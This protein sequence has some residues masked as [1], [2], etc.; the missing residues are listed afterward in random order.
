MRLVRHFFIYTLLMWVAT[1]ADAAQTSLLLDCGPA[2]SPLAEGHTGISERDHYNARRGYG[3]ETQDVFARDVSLGITDPDQAKRT[4]GC[5]VELMQTNLDDANGDFVASKGDLTFRADMKPGTYRVRLRIGD[6]SQAIGSMQIHINGKQ[7]A[8]N[9][10]S[11][12]PGGARG[13]HH[14]R[15]MTNPHGAWRD[16][17]FVVKAADGVIKIKMHGDDSFYRAEVKRQNVSEK[18]WEEDNR[19]GPGDKGKPYLRVDVTKA[20]Y[21]YVGWPF[22]HNAIQAIEIL[23]W[24]EAPLRFVKDRLVVSGRDAKANKLAKLFNGGDYAKLESLLLDQGEDLSVSQAIAA[25]ALAGRLDSEEE[26]ALI[27][28]AAKSLE[29]WLAGNPDAVEV[30]DYLTDAKRYLFAEILHVTRGQASEGENHFVENCRAIAWWWQIR[31][32]SPLY[33]KARLFIAR[34]AKMLIP[35][36]PTRGTERE[37]F[38]ELEK[39]YPDNRFVQYH[40]HKTWRPKGDG[41]KYMDWYMPDRTS[42]VADSPKWVADFYTGFQQTVDWCE[43]W[44]TKKQQPEGSIGG[45][46]SDDV[47]IVGLFGYMGY[48]SPDISEVLVKGTG[49]LINGMWYYSEVDPKR[50]YSRFCADAEH[51]TEP[52]GNTLGMMVQI[53]H[54]NPLWIERSLMTA[55]LYRDLWSGFND[56]GFR[57]YKANYFGATSIGG[58]PGR[59]NDTWINYRALRPMHAVFAYNN[60]PGIAQLMV[61]SG[62]A[63]VDAAM[64]TDRGKPKG[65]IPQ[66]VGWPDGKLGGVQSKNWYTPVKGKGLINGRFRSQGYKPHVQEILRAAYTATLDPKYFEPLRMEYDFVKKHGSLPESAVVRLQAVEGVTVKRKGG[67]G[68]RGKKRAPGQGLQPGSDKW[69]ADVLGNVKMWQTAQ[70]LMK[71]RQGKL[72]NDVTLDDAAACGRHSTRHFKT[73]WPMSTTEAGPTDRIAFFGCVNPFLVATGGWIGGPLL[74][75]SV[76]YENTTRHFAAAVLATDPQGLRLVYHSLSEDDREVGLSPWKLQTGAEYKLTWGPDA[77]NDGKMDKKAGSKTFAFPQIGTLVRFP[78]PSRKSVVVE[79]NQVKAPAR[80]AELLA[81]PGLS[82][83]DLK[84]ANGKLKVSIHNVGAAEAK[85]VVVAAYLGDPA[86]GGKE[87]GRETIEV[88]PPISMELMPSIITVDFDWTGDARQ[89]VHAVIDP[90]GKLL[91]E[92][93]TFNNRAKAQL[94]RTEAEKAALDPSEDTNAYT[95]RRKAAI[96]R[97]ARQRG[98]RGRGR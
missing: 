51:T 70:V 27:A 86:Q 3:W 83:R 64:R 80:E 2:G 32:G 1:A 34:S 4:Y 59:M 68:G 39:K 96:K 56:K 66:C 11:W 58:K 8:K 9:A 16:F 54:G 75:A 48:V 46:F 89:E 71:G 52:T 47:E 60:H 44:I 15:L 73:M 95:A 26:S 42:L 22:V 35:Y 24:K 76:T 50:G 79:I 12:S 7:V 87:I 85:D 72:R 23:P 33:D 97:K 57:H 36:F 90:D 19:T 63:W 5:F 41:S 25:L 88:L 20:P 30:S 74:E 40:L 10:A 53:D 62:D 29:S 67:R 65:I 14:R 78:A 92:I 55:R 69:V 38:K 31:P 94:P 77:D 28:N 18:Q 45:G 61:E 91:P 37:I 49:K 93:T 43:W 21:Y 6:M 17:R 13:G 84:I 98:G 81:D 82:A